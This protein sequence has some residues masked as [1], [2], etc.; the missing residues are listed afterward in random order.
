MKDTGVMQRMF[1]DIN[2]NKQLKMIVNE[3]KNRLN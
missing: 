2:D 1:R 3:S